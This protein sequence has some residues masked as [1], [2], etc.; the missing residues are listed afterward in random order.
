MKYQVVKCPYPDCFAVYTL[1][2]VVV[3]RPLD[4]E[5]MEIDC[6]NCGG[7]TNIFQGSRGLDV[8]EITLNGFRN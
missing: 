3:E 4:R 2:G 1:R 5:Y 6:P 7:L 8:H